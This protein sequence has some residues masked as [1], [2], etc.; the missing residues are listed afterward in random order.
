[1][2]QAD[3][4]RLTFNAGTP[5]ENLALRGIS[6]RIEEGEFVTVIGTNGAG[7]S[8]FLNTIAGTLRVDSGKTC[9]TAW[10]LPRNLPI[11][12][13]PVSLVCSKTPWREL[14]KA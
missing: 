10:T 13:L 12:V 14:A 2:M 8:T 3:N 6:L 11:N 7:K 1:M 5:I 4:L 9:S